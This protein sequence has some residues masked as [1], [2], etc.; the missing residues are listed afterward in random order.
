MY[1]KENTMGKNYKTEYKV[2]REGKPKMKIY[3][4]VKLL[5]NQKIY[6]L[7]AKE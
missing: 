1:I 6:N 3:V 4:H 2:W 5:L 7:K